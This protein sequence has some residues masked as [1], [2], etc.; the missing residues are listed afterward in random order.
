MQLCFNKKVQG[1]TVHLDST[2]GLMDLG[3]SGMRPARGHTECGER[4]RKYERNKGERE[5]IRV[6]WLLLLL[7]VAWI[8][9]K[10]YFGAAAKPHRARPG[11]VLRVHHTQYQALSLPLSLSLYSTPIILIII[12]MMSGAK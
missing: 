11:K 1:K 12:P 6:T 2:S 3:N 4:E 9:H 10:V 8:N 5:K 7:A